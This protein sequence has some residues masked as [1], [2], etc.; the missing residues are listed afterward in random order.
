MSQKKALRKW[1]VIINSAE[2]RPKKADLDQNLRGSKPWV[3]WTAHSS[4]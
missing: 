4:N 3:V 1:K 2:M